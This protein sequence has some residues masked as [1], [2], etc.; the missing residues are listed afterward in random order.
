MLSNGVL[1]S[2]LILTVS[3]SNLYSLF[4]SVSLCH[5]GSVRVDLG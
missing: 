5:V 4:F 1:K 3:F 2:D